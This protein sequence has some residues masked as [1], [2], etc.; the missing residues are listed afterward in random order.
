MEEKLK[1]ML[2]DMIFQ[3]SSLLAQIEKLQS[4]LKDLKE[5]QDVTF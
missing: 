2:G 1:I 3:I 4:E 5:K